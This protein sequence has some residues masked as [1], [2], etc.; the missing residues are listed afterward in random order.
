MCSNDLVGDDDGRIWAVANDELVTG[1]IW[2]SS[3]IKPGL[4]L[5]KESKLFSSDCI[6]STAGG[7]R[8]V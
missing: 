3:F 2:D 1:S 7:I 6:M 5:S 8:G 4:L